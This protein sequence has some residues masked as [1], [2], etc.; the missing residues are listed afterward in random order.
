MMIPIMIL[1]IGIRYYF[2]FT[3]YFSLIT[4][5]QVILY[6]LYFQNL[7]IN[8]YLAFGTL[9]IIS[10]FTI[11]YVKNRFLKKSLIILPFVFLQAFLMTDIFRGFF[12]MFPI[13]I[14]ISLYL[15]NIRSCLN[16]IIF[17]LLSILVLIYYLISIILKY[18]LVTFMNLP[19]EFIIFMILPLEILIFLILMRIIL[20][21]CNL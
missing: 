6:H 9:W 1:F 17:Q 5:K 14:P 7:L 15:F 18:H 19:L 3:S 2:G 21:N 20:R 12:I 16:I 10:L 4:I 8:I 13:L 11:N